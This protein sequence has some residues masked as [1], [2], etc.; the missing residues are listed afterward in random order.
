MYENAKLFLGARRPEEKFWGEKTVFL[1]ERLFYN[2][3][4]FLV[5]GVLNFDFGRKI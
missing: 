5:L 3:F 1:F 2:A 4:R